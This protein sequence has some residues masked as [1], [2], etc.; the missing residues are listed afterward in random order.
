M[1]HESPIHRNYT[2]PPPTASRQAFV[3]RLRRFPQKGFDSRHLRQSAKSA[4]KTPLPSVP[5]VALLA[6]WRLQHYPF[7]LL[8]S[9]SMSEWMLRPMLVML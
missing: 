6:S 8:M 1:P 9:H 5:H 7:R 3:R 4:D 2:T